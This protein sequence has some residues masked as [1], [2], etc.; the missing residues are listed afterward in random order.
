[1]IDEL[2]KRGWIKTSNENEFVKSNW[3]ARID[4]D[5]YEI[6]NNPD[7][8]VGMYHS[9]IILTTDI[10]LLLDEVDEFLMRE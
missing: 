10:D 2:M 1:M 3:T 8:E 4:G 7:T 6:F 9:G 5:V